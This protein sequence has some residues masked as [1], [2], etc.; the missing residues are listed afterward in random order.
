MP[1]KTAKKPAA[2]KPAAKK[3]AA[4]KQTVA[5]PDPAD[6]ALERVRAICLAF[7]GAE[8]KLSHGAPSFHVRG[9]MFLTFVDD[10]HDDGRARGLVQGDARG[11]AAARRDDPER[12]FVPP[13]VGV[14]GWVGVRLDHPETDW[15]ELAILVEEGWAS[16]APKSS[17]RRRRGYPT[18]PRAPAARAREDRREGRPRRARR[19]STPSASPCP[20]RRGGRG[21]ARDVPRGEE[22]RSSTSSTTTTATGSSARASKWRRTGCRRWPEGNARFFL[23]AYIGPRGWVGVRLDAGRPDWN[24][25]GERVVESYLT[26]APKRLHAAVRPPKRRS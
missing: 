6:A 9:K 19:S 2:K 13:Y 25:L 1:P 17:A 15:I 21:A 10:H 16:V 4:K 20:K 3:P 8:E 11:A 12:F 23:P 18:A 5:A 7:T 24:D 26:A 22:G 14:K